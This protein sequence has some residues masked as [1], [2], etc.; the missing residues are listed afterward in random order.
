[1]ELQLAQQ[2]RDR[3]A[4]VRRQH[5]L[6]QPAPALVAEQVCGRAARHQ[7]AVQDRLDLVL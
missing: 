7:V 6:G 3:L 1:M 4:L 2:R 5:L